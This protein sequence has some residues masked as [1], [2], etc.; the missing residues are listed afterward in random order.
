M[1]G[2]HGVPRG[3]RASTRNNSFGLTQREVTTL[4]YLVRGYSNTE[5]AATL[6]ISAKTV[7]HHVSSILAKLGVA[8]RRQ[9]STLALKE[10]IIPQNGE[11]DG[12]N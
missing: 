11:G 7:D 5:I 8:S 1:A 10:K 4:G 6:F 9:A 3:P 12:L 2:M